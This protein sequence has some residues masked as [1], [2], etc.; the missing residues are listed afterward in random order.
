[1]WLQMIFRASSTQTVDIWKR[2]AAETKELSD[3]ESDILP[4]VD[5]QYLLALAYQENGKVKEALELLEHVVLVEERSAEDHPGRL[6]SQHALAIAYR[7][8]GQVTN[9]VEL[10]K[11]VVRV[12][13]GNLR[14]NHPSR[15][16][17]E[18]LLASMVEGSGF[19]V[20]RDIYN[21][22]YEKHVSKTTD[23]VSKTPKLALRPRKKG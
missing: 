22:S 5:V 9:A 12:K 14:P 7:A 11:H 17:S 8:N 16:V 19:L 23:R 10:L 4:V 3:E 18:Q 15:T 6:A 21:P 2:F 20:E 1:M 13:Q